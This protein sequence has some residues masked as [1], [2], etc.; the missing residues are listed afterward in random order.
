MKHFLITVL[1]LPIILYSQ[2]NSTNSKV[3]LGF[4]ALPEMNDL[5]SNNA[6]GNQLESKPKLGFSIGVNTEFALGKKVTLRTGLGYGF[7]NYSTI[8]SGLIFGDDIDPQIGYLSSSKMKQHVTFSELQVPINFLF[9][10]SKHFFI[11]TGVDV[12]IAIA[13]KSERQIIKDNGEKYWLSDKKFGPLVNF[14]PMLSVGYDFALSE[15]TNLMIEPILK[16][17]LREYIIPTTSL[18]NYGIRITY[19]FGI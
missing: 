17:Y 7:K 8:Q 10:L 6:L 13:G 15:N 14:S 4:Y 19:N 9:K 1:L 16:L 12:N 5:I 2:E 11:A 3:K 18:Y